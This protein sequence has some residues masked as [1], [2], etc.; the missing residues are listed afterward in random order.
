M[1]IF[2]HQRSKLTPLL[3]ALVLAACGA[4]AAVDG[5]RALP[6]L[7]DGASTESAIDT[8]VLISRR[9]RRLTNAE[10]GA[11]LSQLLGPLE[12]D[13]SADFAPDVRQQGFTVNAEQRV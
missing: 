10:Y 9:I 11:S 5:E 7:D 2:F 8:S 12:K 4:E 3:A 6:R 1:S 13:P